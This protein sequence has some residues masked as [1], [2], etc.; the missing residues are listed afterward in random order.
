MTNC[1]HGWSQTHAGNTLY[2]C[3]QDENKQF[4][5]AMRRAGRDNCGASLW[6]AI[7][8]FLD[9]F[10]EGSAHPMPEE[11]QQYLHNIQTV[12]LE[13]FVMATGSTFYEHIST[14]G[15]QASA[16]GTW[17]ADSFRKCA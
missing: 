7:N 15:R 16:A 12:L 11:L 3:K 6:M 1:W 8:C 2:C 10:D 13:S 4:P 5:W 9:C 14:Q 17:C